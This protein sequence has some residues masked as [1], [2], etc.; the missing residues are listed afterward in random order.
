MSGET[1]SGGPVRPAGSHLKTGLRDYGML[2]SLVAIMLFFQ[3]MTG[4]TLLRPLNLT[5]LVLQNSFIVIMALGMLLVI[6]TGHIDLSVGSVAGAVG[7]VAAV[8]MVR[9]E[10]HFVPAA[11]I[12]LALGA[13]IGAAQGYWVAY[14]K[15]PSFIVTLAGMLVFKGLAL[16]ILQGQSL[17]P[18]PVTFQK[19]SSGFIPELMPEAG[20]LYPTSLAIGAALAI[21]LVVLN[22]KS[23]MRQQSHG[24][25]VEPQGFFIA[26]NLAFAA[27]ILYATYLIASYRGLPNVLVVMG[28]LI[29]LYAF[30]TTRT[31]IGR[32]IY[33]V[34]GNARAAKLSGV[35]T[36]WLT[37]LTFVNMGVLAAL[38]GLVFAARLNTATPKAG[39]GFELDVIA[40][41]FI[42]GASAYGGV[43]RVSGA[44]IGALIMGVMNNGMSILGIGIDY[45]QVIKGLVLLG[46]VCLDVYNQKR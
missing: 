38:A 14:F 13:L 5:N 8:L 21:L 9:Y 2:M 23:R 42:G 1:L 34:G 32:Q 16:A 18:F 28:L 22:L 43:G 24:I 17:G 12:C 26:K 30:V 11:L 10:M 27:I 45:Q 20:A 25:P 40:A 29:A 41:C 44:V 39:L 33:A 4:G 19:L 31:S 6:V 46:A 37:F 35:R 3:V 7:A 15:I 36:E